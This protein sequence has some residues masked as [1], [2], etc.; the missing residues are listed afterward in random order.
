MLTYN[1]LVLSDLVYRSR[2]PQLLQLL[3]ESEFVAPLV[4]EVSEVCD[5]R[6]SSVAQ[7]YS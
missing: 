1:H 2:Y 4:A 5:V 3:F 7:E 6:C